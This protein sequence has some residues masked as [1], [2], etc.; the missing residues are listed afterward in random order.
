VKRIHAFGCS[1]T[2][3]H[4]WRHLQGVDTTSYAVPGGSH[5]MQLVM[6]GNGRHAE[7]IGRDDIII[8]QMTDPRRQA[9]NVKRQGGMVFYRDPVMSRG[10]TLNQKDAGRLITNNIYTGKEMDMFTNHLF[11][12]W[13]KGESLHSYCRIEAEL[14]DNEDNIYPLLWSLNGI[15][16]MNE[17]LIVVFGWD[18]G[19]HN[20]CKEKMINFFGLNGIAHIEPSILNWTIENGYKQS[21]TNHPNTEG[22]KAFTN[23]ILEPKLQQL[24]WI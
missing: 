2:A 23:E 16:R 18:E 20:G 21:S 10:V 6:Y 19:L 9:Y 7:T 17:K 8:W 12:H 11:A 24:G 4:R 13:F 14:A 3:Q 5:N 15:K 1:L 22:Y